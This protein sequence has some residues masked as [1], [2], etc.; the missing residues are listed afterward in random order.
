M[1]KYLV[2][3]GMNWK[4][5]LFRISIEDGNDEVTE[6]LCHKGGQDYRNLWQ[7]TTKKQKKLDNFFKKK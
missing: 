4:D 1:M 5:Q 2:D 6:Y 7:K 3:N